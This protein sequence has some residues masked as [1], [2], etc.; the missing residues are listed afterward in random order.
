[1]ELFETS[2]IIKNLHVFFVSFKEDIW[3]EKNT[4]RLRK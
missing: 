3:R 1:M 2:Q 4:K